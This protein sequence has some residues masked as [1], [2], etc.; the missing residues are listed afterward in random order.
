[1][2]FQYFNNYIIYFNQT[3]TSLNLFWIIEQQPLVAILRHY[4]ENVDFKK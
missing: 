1:M 3:S 2:V 4:R